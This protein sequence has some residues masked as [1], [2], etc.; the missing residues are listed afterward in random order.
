MR[1]VLLLC[2][3][4]LTMAAQTA[5]APDPQMR[6]QLEFLASDELQG[7]G[8]ATEFEAVAAAY[9]ASEMQRMGLRPGGDTKP[10]IHAYIQEVPFTER[11]IKGVPLLRAGDKQWRHG[12][13][14]AAV[15]ITSPA[16]SGPLQ[17][18]S[19]DAQVTKGSVVLAPAETGATRG[20]TRELL[21]AGAAAVLLMHGP[22]TAERYESASKSELKLLDLSAPTHII[23]LGPEASAAIHALPDGT[24]IA[25]QAEVEMLQRKTR[26]VI[27]SIAGK[28][29][30]ALILS[31][32][33]D[34]LGTKTGEGDVIFNG[35]DDD[36]SGS[37]TVLGLARAFAKGAQPRRTVYFVLYGSEELGGLGSKHFL[38]HLPVPQEK[39][40]MNV[41]FEMLGRPDPKVAPAMLWMTGFDRSNLGPT[42]ASKGAKVAADP[43]PDQMFFER[44]DNFSMAKKGVVAHTISSFPLHGE[45]HQA[46]DDIAHIDFAH[47]SS[48][49]QSLASPMRWLADSDFKPEW[50]AGKKP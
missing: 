15:A 26:N 40:A 16:F 39:I 19:A 17:K 24:Q 46:N 4:S 2:F 11:R 3:S 25:F 48:A 33:F 12:K 5:S 37:V 50:A 27:G 1:A 7:R 9:L 23:F 43:Y 34:H 47:L 41:Q 10:G 30:E 45:Y 8:S 14:V 49:I 36:A 22:P 31:A 6:A 21:R 18:L 38:A 13:D 44:S 32:H 42:L 29:D 35:A 28:T 20:T